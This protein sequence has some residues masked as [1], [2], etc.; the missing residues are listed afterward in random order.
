M[1][2]LES[3]MGQDRGQ[4]EVQH[5]GGGIYM[6]PLFKLLR[7][8]GV[9]CYIGGVFVGLVIYA[10]DIFLLAPNRKSA[11]ILLSLCEKFAEE[12]NIMFSTH[13]DPAKS[14]SKAMFMTGRISQDSLPSPLIL[15]GKK[16]PWVSRCQHLGHTFTS[17]GSL[18]QDCKEKRAAFIDAAV[19]TREMFNFAHP[20]EKTSAIEKYCTTFYGSNLWRLDSTGVDQLESSWRTSAKLSYDLP[21]HCHRYVIDNLLA[22]DIWPIKSSLLSRF[23]GFFGSLILSD[24]P[25]VQLV[26]R[27]AAR[28]VRSSLGSN[29]RLIHDMTDLNPWTTSRLV[30]KERLRQVTIAQT[31]QEDYWRLGAIQSLL[32]ERQLAFYDSNDEKEQQL[33]TLIESLVKN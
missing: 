26:T 32:S 4:Q 11:Q 21:R 17:D 24:S 10:D 6:N 8:S 13:N 14:R 20:K 19:K 1:K 31:P 29:L 7:E 22:P 3:R 30:M 15:C 25:E 5:S 12:N 16:L 18:D 27:L 2:P 9:G 23:H 33:T 28:D